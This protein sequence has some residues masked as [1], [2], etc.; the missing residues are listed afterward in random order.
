MSMLWTS[1][2]SGLLI[3]CAYAGAAVGLSLAMGMARVFNLA[4]TAFGLTCG[5]LAY[6]LLTTTGIDPLVAAGLLAPLL[7]LDPEP[8]G[9]NHSLLESG[10]KFTGPDGP[11]EPDGSGRPGAGFGFSPLLVS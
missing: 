7:F 5:Y 10:D 1:L 6:F 9:H 4:H 11:R 8:K 3:G 2:V